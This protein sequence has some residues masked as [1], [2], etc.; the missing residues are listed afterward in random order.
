L[1]ESKI[2]DGTGYDMSTVLDKLSYWVYANK[3]GLAKHDVASLISAETFKSKD[4]SGT[5][6]EGVAGLAYLAGA[7]WTYSTTRYLG[8]SVNADKGGYWRGV[9]TAAHELA[10]KYDL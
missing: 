8:T 3:N 9:F 6:V 10:H 2:P 5:Y 4:S 7:C 1:E